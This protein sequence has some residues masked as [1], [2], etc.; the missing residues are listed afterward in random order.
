MKTTTKEK[1]NT[2]I[3]LLLS[4]AIG[5]FSPLLMYITLARKNE[6]YKY[7]CRKAFNFHLLIFLLFN[8][9]SRISDVLFWIV[10][11]FEVV[12]VIIV[13]W[14]VIRDEPYRYFIRIPLFKEDKYIVEG[15]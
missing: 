1:R 8:I 9:S 10:F 14:K 11:A 12:Q 2:I 13:A 5:I 7:H 3:M 6:V 15:E 4:A